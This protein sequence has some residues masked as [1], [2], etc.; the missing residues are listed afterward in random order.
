MKAQK[1]QAEEWGEQRYV[2]LDTPL[3]ELAEVKEDDWP[4]FAVFQKGLLRATKNALVHSK[5]VAG[6]GSASEGEVLA[7]WIEFLDTCWDRGL[8]KVKGQVAAVG[9]TEFWAGISLNPGSRTVKW[10][11][12]SVERISS[13]LTLW[14]QIYANKLAR[15]GP[16]LKKAEA[17]R[18]DESHPGAKKALRVL[19]GALPPTVK[20]GEDD[21]AEEEVTKRVQRRLRAILQLGRHGEASS[22]DVDEETEETEE[23]TPAPDAGD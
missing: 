18:G 14:W 10:S 23:A 19:R 22:S 9:T 21:L 5:S 4:F 16:F 11:D 15:V 1:K 6:L 2:K 12:A 13:L 20:Y 3:K 17:P 7:K 8:L